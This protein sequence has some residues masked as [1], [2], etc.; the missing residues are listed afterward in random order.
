MAFLKLKQTAHTKAPDQVLVF[1]N[2]YFSNNPA[3]KG[4]QWKLEQKV[5]TDQISKVR[6]E[7]AASIAEKKRERLKLAK[8]ETEKELKERLKKVEDSK[9]FKLAMKQQL[10]VK[11]AELKKLKVIF[12]QLEHMCEYVTDIVGG[13]L[14]LQLN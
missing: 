6:K 13:C 9:D 12:E 2:R 3:E 8:I 14:H 10:A 5:Y 11:Q 1:I 7:Y 4:K